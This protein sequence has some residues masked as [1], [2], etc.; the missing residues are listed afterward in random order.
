M[1]G[2]CVKNENLVLSLLTSSRFE[3]NAQFCNRVS[4]LF[5]F[6]FLRSD[7]VIALLVVRFPFSVGSRKLKVTRANRDSSQN[8]VTVNY[9]LKVSRD[10]SIPPQ[11][12]FSNTSFPP[13]V[14]PVAMVLTSTMSPLCHLPTNSKQLNWSLSH[15]IRI[16]QQKQLHFIFSL[17]LYS[18]STHLGSQTRNF[19]ELFLLFLLNTGT[20][21]QP[22]LHL[23]QQQ[24]QQHNV[25]SR[26]K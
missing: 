18:P 9:N 17:H 4:Q 2:S 20:T 13:E 11:V 1:E 24:Q 22:F 3:R 21:A 5:Y 23:Q 25:T 19:T 16:Q 10:Y 8:L 26:E 14:K 7:D 15:N 6:R 12:W